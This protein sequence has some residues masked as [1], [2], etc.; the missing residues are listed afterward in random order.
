MN[1]TI[2][3]ITAHARR[4]G[5]WWYIEIPELGTS[6]QARTIKEIEAVAHEIA[7]LWLD[8]DESTIEAAVT[9]EL[10]QQAAQ[11]WDEANAA[12]IKAREGAQAA[13]RLRRGAVA[14]LKAEGISQADAA[15]VLGVSEQRI[16]QLAHA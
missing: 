10:P 16:S 13:A 15:R 3:T 14:A 4:D 1:T 8:V 5:R 7:A 6:G 2:R 9:V 11:L 12:D